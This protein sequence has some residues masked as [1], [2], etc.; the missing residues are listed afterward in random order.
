MVACSAF[1]KTGGEYDFFTDH[2]LVEGGAQVYY[3]YLYIY[4]TRTHTYMYDIHV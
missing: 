2:R 4:Y 3:F 1:L